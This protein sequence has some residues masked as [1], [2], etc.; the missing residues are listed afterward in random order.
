LEGVDKNYAWMVETRDW[1]NG[2]RWI[3]S[4]VSTEKDCVDGLLKDGHPGA[5]VYV[6]KLQTDE[7]GNNCHLGDQFAVQE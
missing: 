1:T 6:F 2:W 7:N 4:N 5:H 3:H